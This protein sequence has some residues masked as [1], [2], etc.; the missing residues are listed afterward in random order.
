MT[1]AATK[2]RALWLTE[3]G[4]DEPPAPALRG[5]VRADVTIVGGGFLGL[6]TA[7]RIKQH[8]PGRSVAIVEQD[9]CG[10]GASGRNGGF[11]L[12]WWAKLPSLAALFGIEEAKRLA[13]QSADAVAELGR[14]SAL[15]GIDAQFSDAG[16]IWSA[17]APA[18]VGAWE[19]AVSLCERAG[20]DVWQR[21]APEDLHAR[22]GSERHVAGVLDTTS[23][24]VQ[25]AAL[26]RGMRRV[27]LE[28]GVQIFEHTPVR[29]LRR[30]R[31]CVVA[32][33]AGR[34]TSEKLVLA[35]NAWMA[36]LHGL[37][38]ALVV[39]SSDIV[40]TAPIPEQL[41]RIGWTS[42]EVITDSQQMVLYYRRTPEGRV[43][44]GKG[45]WGLAF[46]GHIGAQFDRHRGRA[47]ATRA[48]F[49][50][51]YPGLADVAIET[52]WSGP[53]DRSVDGLPLLGHLGRRRD[54]LFGAGF[55]GNGVAPS[56]LGGQVLASLALERD[57][58]WSAHPL[59]DRRIK[60]FPPEPLRFVGAH[61]V[62]G[63]VRRKDRAAIVG[64]PAPRIVRLVAGL[65]PSGLEDH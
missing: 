38:G 47:E 14:F 53:I 45:G 42:A 44:F 56:A 6:W 59:V 46:G 28:L 29:W 18:H 3:A 62:K 23:G 20:V 11:A 49:R 35:G 37:R 54:V 16:W 10:G 32:S 7:I 1:T 2:H 31:G 60:R 4:V 24:S 65:A 63:A 13:H 39:V 5:A 8:E 12:S 57:D 26:A 19:G 61:V 25:P 52:D 17:T 15:H 21:L 41:E 48:E 30:E 50:R 22:T 58:E 40:A 64:R 36:G 51:V 9:V 55:S 34:L 27:A 43:V 33:D